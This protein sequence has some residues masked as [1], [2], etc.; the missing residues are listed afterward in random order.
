MVIGLAP[1]LNFGSKEMKAK[2]GLI[3]V[4]VRSLLILM[5]PQVIPEVLSGK[6]YI[7]LAISEAFAGSDVAGLRCSAVKSDDGKFWIV[8]G[9]KKW[10]TVRRDQ[11][12]GEGLGLIPL[13]A[14]RHLLRLLQHRRTHRQGPHDD[15]HRAW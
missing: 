5:S 7:S 4:D 8:N 9:T 1:V 11:V 15:A 3:V 14:E 10:I 2:V 13:H 12:R 6:K